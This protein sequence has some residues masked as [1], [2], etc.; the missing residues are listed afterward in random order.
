MRES[1]VHYNGATDLRCPSDAVRTRLFAMVTARAKETG[2]VA[3]KADGRLCAVADALVALMHEGAPPPHEAADFALSQVG[4][5]EPAP[6]FIV[7]MSSKAEPELLASEFARRLVHL[8]TSSPKPRMGV[9]MA[10]LADGGVV[11]GLVLQ[12]SFVQLAPILREIAPGMRPEISGR[13]LPPYKDPSVLVTAP[14]GKVTPLSLEMRRGE[15]KSVLVCDDRPGVYQVEVLGHGPQGPSVLANFPVYCGQ[16]APT[17]LAMAPRESEA[18]WTEPSSEQ[19]ILRLLN[20]D[21]TRAGLPPLLWSEPAAH[22][23]R[24]HS[25]EMRDKDFVAHVSPT[26]G[27]VMA[28]VRKAKIVSP[29]T[30]ENL[31]RAYAPRDVHHGLMNS[32]GHRQNILHADATHV[33]IGVA[34]EG[35]SGQTPALFVTQVFLRELAKVDVKEE[36]KTLRAAVDTFR[37]N[38]G[39]K[40]WSRDEG[41]EKVAQ[42]F[43]KELS[44]SAGNLSTARREALLGQAPRH[45]RAVR[46]L[47]GIVTSARDVVSDAVLASALGVGVGIAQGAH[48]TVGNN[49]LYV[50]VLLGE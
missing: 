30:L 50:V 35:A 11:V 1:S 15:F 4:V 44:Q 12:D 37:K 49:A 40:P 18:A 32:P 48:A 46:A 13:L 36:R 42:D 7:L 24:L 47:V 33:G 22:V 2:S 45:F 14:N 34:L 25:R 43:A 27:D 10:N 41:L 19:E 5:I 39:A 21:R 9:G 29:L 23:A 28:R 6:N 38:H 31:A 17:A 20:A 8:P 16:K 3:P 26:T